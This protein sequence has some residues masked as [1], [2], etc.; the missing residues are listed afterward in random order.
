M[1][2]LL[3][4]YVGIIALRNGIDD[5]IKGARATAVLC[6]LGAVDLPIIHFSVVWWRT[7]HQPPSFSKASA[8]PAISGP[9]LPPL[10]WMSIAF[11]FLGAYLIILKTREIRA[12]RTL[13]TIEA[14]RTFTHA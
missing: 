8:S 12:R 9:L 2:V 1:L 10:I 3:I 6:I 7:L 14:E 11:T 5:P 13:D 4:L